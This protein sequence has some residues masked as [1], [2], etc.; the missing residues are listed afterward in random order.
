MYTCTHPVRHRRDVHIDMHAQLVVKRFAFM[1][2]NT[3]TVH[4]LIYFKRSIKDDNR[5]S[6]IINMIVYLFIF[7]CRWKSFLDI[8]CQ[9]VKHE[10]PLIRS[11]FIKSLGDLCFSRLLFQCQYFHFVPVWTCRWYTIDSCLLNYR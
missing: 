3:D 7:S 2:N 8:S 5:R 11:S 9:L 10:L 1:S 6:M 4:S